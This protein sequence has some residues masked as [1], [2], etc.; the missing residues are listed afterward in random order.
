MSFHLADLAP[1][2]AVNI[3]GNGDYLSAV[4]VG[5]AGDFQGQPA[6]SG[7]YVAHTLTATDNAGNPG[8]TP[9]AVAKLGIDTSSTYRSQ[10]GVYL[11]SSVYMAKNQKK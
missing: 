8:S 7:T 3:S 2:A 9:C 4:T 6:A 10:Q 11:E 1:S 5:A